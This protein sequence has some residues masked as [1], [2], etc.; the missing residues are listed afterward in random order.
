MS[1]IEQQEI[2]EKSTCCFNCRY[3]CNRTGFCRKNPPQVIVQYIN[4][5]AFPTAIFP[6]IAVPAIDWC[7]NFEHK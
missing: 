5:S 4:R 1:E 6:K 2:D 7:G 3:F